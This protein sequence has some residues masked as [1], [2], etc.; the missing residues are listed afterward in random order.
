MRLP[1]NATIAHEKVS[2]YLLVRQSRGDKSAFLERAGFTSANPAALT[3]AIQAIRD[4]N[5]ALLV[6]ESKFGRYYEVVGTMT[7]PNGTALRVKTIW[8]TEHLSGATK[9]ITLIPLEVLSQ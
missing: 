8:M 4:G 9:F 3:A 6:D 2:Q 7:G 5:D 1:Q